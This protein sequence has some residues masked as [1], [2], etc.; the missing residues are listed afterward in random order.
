MNPARRRSLGYAAVTLAG[1]LALA[2]TV[3]PGDGRTEI[4]GE[5][6]ATA[7]D[8]TVPATRYA[9]PADAI[10]VAPAGQ[11][12]AS[13]TVAAP[14]RT[15]AAAVG[16][17][18]PGQTIVLRGGTYRET[19]GKVTKRIV[20]Q[21]YP[22]EQ[23]WLKG[24]VVV[25]GWSRS[26]GGWRHD[27]WDVDLCHS[28][29]LG[30]I[31]DP[32]HPF[33]GLPDMVFVNGKP[34]RQVG[35]ADDVGPGRFFVDKAAK[36]LII[37]DDPAGRTVEATAFDRLVQL[38]GEGARGSVLRGIGVA[39]YAS[40]QDYGNR[41]AM[42]VANAPDVTIENATFAWSA[43][44]GAA[45]Y[46]PGG[47]VTGSTFTDNGLAGLVANRAD[48]LRVTGSTFSR[49]NQ[50]R[51]ALSGEAIGASGAKIAHTRQPYIAGNVFADNI[52]TGWW[53]DLG[54]TD[55][56]VIRNVA[57]G[58]AVNGLYYEVSS[59]AIIASNVLVGNRARGL[60][61]SSSDHVRVY[62][63]TFADNA[64]NLGL[65]N[66]PR[67][68]SSD[69]YSKQNGLSWYTTDTVLVNNF[70]AQPKPANPI[71]DSA[72]HKDEPLEGHPFV[73]L[74]D[75][76]AYLRGK[77]GTPAPLVIWSLGSG[78]TAGYPTLAEFTRATGRDQHSLAAD[79]AGS[80]FT[81]P[82]KNNFTLRSGTP[83]QRAGQPLPADI[84][85]VLGVPPTPNPDIGAL[86]Q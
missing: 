24:T 21:P 56:V 4:P 3:L 18:R 37:G 75:G 64:T 20:L 30:A 63:N 32:A 65:Y 55:A 25:N 84:A 73:V 31:I 62:Q 67:D 8:L 76:N 49:N 80:P 33:A 83:G 28:C 41:G 34:L 77:S 61:I 1:V 69:N 10:V 54:C 47:K 15:V 5:P 53:C 12:G 42:V 16:R 71:I 78:K 6:A 14:L 22:D 35:D 19:L 68:P 36:A 59:R 9:V 26:G 52:G 51:F 27:G 60:K 50:E 70:F 17:A 66:D 38:D 44:S 57:K 85:A 45:V 29:F 2:F 46:Q 58:N 39:Q 48:G 74:S 7:V 40:N 86:P 82:A 81:D 43:S 11:D 23:A 13:G 79:L 72:D